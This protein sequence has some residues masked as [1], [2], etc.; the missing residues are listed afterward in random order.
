MSSS[1]CERRKGEVDRRKKE[2]RRNWSIGY[3]LR[4]ENWWKHEELVG[5]RS[6]SKE[7]RGS[8]PNRRKMD[9]RKWD[10][11]KGEERRKKERRGGT[12]IRRPYMSP[13][14]VPEQVM[15]AR[16][17]SGGT[18]RP[19][20]IAGGTAPPGPAKIYNHV[21]SAQKSTAPALPTAQWSPEDLEPSPFE[22]TFPGVLSSLKLWLKPA[23][24][25]VKKGWNSLR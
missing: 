8:T 16:A 20:K 19:Q 23:V 18:A 12:P 21:A 2:Q 22:S 25:K 3:E 5:R 24:Q 14:Y 11:R 9:R 13:R 1:P 17:A 7:K 6:K 10:N 15:Q 4:D